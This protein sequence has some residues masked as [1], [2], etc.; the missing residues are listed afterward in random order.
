MFFCDCCHVP[1]WDR[2]HEPEGVEE[3]VERMEREWGG[4][5]LCVPCMDRCHEVGVCCVR[6]VPEDE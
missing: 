6:P 2:G 5:L 3:Y 1:M 4:E